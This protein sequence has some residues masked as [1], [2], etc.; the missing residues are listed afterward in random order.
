MQITLSEL[1]VTELKALAYD[2]I[3]Q[4]ETANNGLNAISQELN[5]RQQQPQEE[6]KQEAE[7]HSN[8]VEA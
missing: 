7:V 4:R 2:L 1:S 3:A 8:G 6:I 5:K